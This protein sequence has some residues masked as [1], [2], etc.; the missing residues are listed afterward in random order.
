MEN[1][2]DIIFLDAFTPRCHSV[3]HVLQTRTPKPRVWKALSEVPALQMLQILGILSL[4]I[5]TTNSSPSFSHFFQDSI[6]HDGN[7]MPQASKFY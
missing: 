7:T 1:A 3:L 5:G 6:E 2:M 4:S